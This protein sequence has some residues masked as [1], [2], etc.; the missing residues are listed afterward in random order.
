MSENQNRLATVPLFMM[1]Y[2]GSE[3]EPEL[4]SKRCYIPYLLKIIPMQ[5]L[6]F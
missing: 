3:N 6:K 2:C 1:V 4:L 5:T